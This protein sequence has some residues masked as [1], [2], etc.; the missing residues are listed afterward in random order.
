MSGTRLEPLGRVRAR[1]EVPGDKSIS[2][3]ALIFNALA[4]GE[5]V[6]RNLSPGHDV[7]STA[8]ALVALGTSLDRV[9]PAAIR[10][11]GP[12][13]WTAKRPVEC[14]NAGTLARLLLGILA[15]RARGRVVLRGDASLSGRPMDR[16]TRPLRAMG[17]AIE[18]TGDGGEGDRLPLVV[19]GRP[20]AGREHRLAVASAQVK[21]A[22]LLAGLAGEGETAVVEPGTSR[23]HTERILAAMGAELQRDP[24]ARRIAVRPGGLAS[25]DLDVP[26]D[27]SSA[28]FFLAFAAARPG[29]EV[30]IEDVGVNPTRTGF[31]E[32]LEAMGAGVEVELEETDP[33][34]RGTVRVIGAELEGVDVDP[35]L[36]PRAI[37]ELPLLAVVATAARGE[38]RVTGAAELRVKE[39]D[40][41]AAISAGLSRMGGAIEA[42]PDGFVVRGPTP[43][44]G[45]KLD[46]RGDHRIG[47]ALAVAAAL[48][49]SPSA[50]AGSE[51]IDVSYPGF[52][53]DL[54]SCSAGAATGAARS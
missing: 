14:G 3:R 51:W 40:R 37:D 29:N 47:M 24:A 49:D 9:G 25:L 10:V 1:L 16:V 6:V 39:S 44:S 35:A 33:E 23:D 21:S 34:P 26:G 4:S 36:V 48:A 19:E 53:H 32:V 13:E 41:I 27:L 12:T 22:L 38:T 17:A 8:A 43:L 45:A 28:A 42:R 5:A 2:H 50:L 30:T 7:A 18:A 11:A 31:L 15:P 52:L 54:G 20:L 46:A